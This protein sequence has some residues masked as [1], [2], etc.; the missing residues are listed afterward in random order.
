MPRVQGGVEALQSRI[1]IPAVEQP[2]SGTVGVRLL[3]DETGAVEAEEI[4]QS[5]G[6][7][8]DEEVL[9]VLQSAEFEPAR[10]Q[11]KPV[12]AWLNLKFKFQ[13]NS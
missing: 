1:R 9:R 10:I 4:L 13:M 7:G 11:N 6:Y 2:V 5:V 8:Y 3:I 12:K